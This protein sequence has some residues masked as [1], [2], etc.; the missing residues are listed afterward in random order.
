[1][2]AQNWLS[3]ISACP[4]TFW[5]NNCNYFRHSVS[6]DLLFCK[7]K[8]IIIIIKKQRMDMKMK[9]HF[10][11]NSEIHWSMMMP[12]DWTL[13]YN[14]ININMNISSD[15]DTDDRTFE[16]VRPYINNLIERILNWICTVTC[17]WYYTFKY[18]FLLCYY[19]T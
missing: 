1:M 5:Q 17:S 11:K 4:I 8:D 2:W 15:T 12:S 7:N 3:F 18:M 13:R 16:L 14:T 10:I 6:S 9:Y 19:Q